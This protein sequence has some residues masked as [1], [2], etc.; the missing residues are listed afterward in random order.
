VEGGKYCVECG[1]WKVESI[2]L[3]VDCGRWKVLCRVWI[4]EGV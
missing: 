1:L 3:N 4:V 2:V